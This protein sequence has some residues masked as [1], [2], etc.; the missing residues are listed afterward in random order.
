VAG[1]LQDRF[2]STRHLRIDMRFRHQAVWREAHGQDP[3]S[4]VKKS[5]AYHTWFA[6]P[7]RPVSDARAPF[8]LPECL[9]MVLSKN[10]MRNVARFRIREHGLKC[11][12]GL[13]GR[14]PDRSARFCYLCENGDIL[15]EKHAIY[16]VRAPNIYGTSST[17]YFIISLTVI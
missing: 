4:C 12:T 14:S 11:E 5:V 7:H 6:L 13:Y 3:C 17:I 8:V 10:V 2:R 1:W 9:R 15:D 16:H